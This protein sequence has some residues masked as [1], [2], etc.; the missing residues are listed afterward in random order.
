M[1]RASRPVVVGTLPTGNWIG[2]VSGEAGF[3]LAVGA[4][5]REV[6]DEAP[7]LHGRAIL[8]A[9]AIAYF[10]EVLDEPPPD[11]SEATH[12][13]VAELVGWLAGTAVNP[14][15]RA[16]GRE[17]LDAVEDGLAGDA[18]AL[19]LIALLEHTE[20]R[21]PAPQASADPVELLAARARALLGP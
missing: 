3:R 17:A 20:R 6:L 5:A 21:T 15:E 16:A 11:V 8:T 18:V 19:L 7:P 9:L 10:E 1:A 4:G 2:F 14:A 12:Q 13:D